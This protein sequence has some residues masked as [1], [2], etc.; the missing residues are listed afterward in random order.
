MIPFPQSVKKA[1]GV[2]NGVG[3]GGSGGSGGAAASDSDSSFE[4]SDSHT[5]PSSDISTNT[6]NETGEEDSGA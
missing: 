1:G 6:C 4:H 5:V 3:V 2:G